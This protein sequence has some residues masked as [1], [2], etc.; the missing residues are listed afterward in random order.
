MRS[1]TTT[2]LA[3]VCSLLFLVIPFTVDAQKSYEPFVI[4]P[5]FD[6]GTTNN[7]PD[8]INKL[9]VLLIV[10]GSAFAVIKII[11]AGFKWS[12]SDIVS[13]K[14]DAM[15][16]IQGVL[17]GLAI[18][19]APAIVL[20]TINSDLTDLNILRGFGEAVSVNTT[21]VIQTQE[22]GTSGV[23]DP[24]AGT[25]AASRNDIVQCKSSEQNVWVS[26]FHTET[27]LFGPDS[28]E[29]VADVCVP[30][31][32]VENVEGCTEDTAGNYLCRNATK[33][34]ETFRLTDT[35]KV[36]GCIFGISAVD[37][38]GYTSCQEIDI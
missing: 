21:P 7:L 8:L 19:V 6:Y 4:I 32:K 35:A 24:N 30:R 28:M 36:E 11:V 1:H 10:A 26:Y 13:N 27:H 29:P 33:P 22:T 17:L 12:T 23:W 34:G 20:N 9:Y 14:H 25:R 2:L 16:D 15:H 31:S 37:V 3:A 18:L 5:G 38:Q